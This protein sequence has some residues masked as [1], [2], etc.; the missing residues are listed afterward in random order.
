M[1]VEVGVGVGV[2]VRV[3]VEVAVGVGVGQRGAVLVTE[4]SAG[5]GGGLTNRLIIYDREI[6]TSDWNVRVAGTPGLP[7]AIVSSPHV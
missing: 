2:G 1:F 5:A 4:T 6:Q 3:L 7:A